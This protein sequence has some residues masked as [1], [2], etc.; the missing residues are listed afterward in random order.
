MDF[1]EKMNY[2]KEKLEKDYFSLYPG[3]KDALNRLYTL[4][5]KHHSN[6]S[7]ALKTRDQSGSDWLNAP[8]TIG[9]MLYV[10]LFSS[11]LN[12]LKSH[13]DYFKEL[14]V[15]LIHLMPILKPRSG[16]ND[17][18]YAVQDYRSIDTRIGT[19]EDFMALVKHYHNNGIRICIDYVVNHTANDHEWATKALSGEEKYQNYYYMFDSDAIP[20]QFEATLLEVFPKVAPGNFTY[21]EELEKWVMTTFY[22]FQWDLNFRNPEV[23]YEMVDNLLYLTDIGVDMIRLD[24]IPYIWKTIGTDCR[25]LPEVHVLLSLFRKIIE[26]CAPSTTLLGEAIVEPDAIVKYFGAEERLECHSLYNASYMVEIW[27]SIATRDSR[28]IAWMKDYEI[29]FGSVWINYARCHD[30]IGWGL[31]AERLKRMGFDPNAHKSF[32]IDFY[33]GS[34]E[35]SFSTGELYEFNPMTMD[36][37]NSGTLASLAGLEKAIKF[38]DDYLLELALKRIRLINALFLLRKGIPMIYSGDEIGQLNNTSYLEDGYKKND[39]R[40]L[41]RVEFDWEKI[42]ETQPSESVHLQVLKSMKQL[43]DTRRNYSGDAF[44]ANETVL[45]QSNTHLLVIHQISEKNE[46]ILLIFN[47]SED[48]Q[49]LYS[50]ELKRY[51]VGGVWKEIIQGKIIDLDK[52]RIVLGPYEF[53]VMKI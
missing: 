18:G 48:R 21:L 42:G 33:L 14:G 28:H 20:R 24:A 26:I 44:I 27:N 39:S 19:M 1:K 6:R 43:I 3:R 51:G 30:D 35:D 16:E 38:S 53:F 32:L 36:A 5:R 52:K 40:W 11:N 29:P 46:S 13:S 7:D 12:K 50:N 49:W 47:F 9:V 2:Q 25:N 17:G 22:P 4:M 31:D 37:R 10:D 23:F 8:N 15:T 41:H 45:M 34:L